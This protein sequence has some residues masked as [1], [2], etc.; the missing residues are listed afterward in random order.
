M[1]HYSLSGRTI[2]RVG[3]TDMAWV[4]GSGLGI[5]GKFG[6][7][8]RVVGLRDVDLRVLNSEMWIWRW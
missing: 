6:V 3:S 1:R 5:W 2:T 4:G 8:L 7:E